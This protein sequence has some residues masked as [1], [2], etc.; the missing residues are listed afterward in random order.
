MKGKGQKKSNKKFDIIDI[1]IDLVEPLYILT[2]YILRS[3]VRLI[4]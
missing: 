4:D 2:R 1:G 3:I